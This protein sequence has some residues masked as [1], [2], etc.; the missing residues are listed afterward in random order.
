MPEP[1]AERWPPRRYGLG[2]RR[3]SARHA[4]RWLGRH[5]ATQRAATCRPSAP[6]PGPRPCTP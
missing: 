2:C 5:R 1:T 4:G 6:S 3:R